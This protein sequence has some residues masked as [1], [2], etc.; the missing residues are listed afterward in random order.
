MLIGSWQRRS[1][2]GSHV[3]TSHT[4][5]CECG[6]VPCHLPPQPL[7]IKL[8]AS[9]HDYSVPLFRRYTTPLLHLTVR[10]HVQHVKEDN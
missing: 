5:A 8:L 10:P 2:D 1:C 9:I 3:H 7:V 6:F 4:R